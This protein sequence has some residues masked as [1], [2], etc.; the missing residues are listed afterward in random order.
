VT[1]FRPWHTVL[2]VRT[3][4]Q[5]RREIEQKRERE[6]YGPRERERMS[7]RKRERESE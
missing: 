7:M 1:A 3:W 2:H 5:D 6:R 4:S